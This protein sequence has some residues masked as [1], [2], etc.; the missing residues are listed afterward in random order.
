MTERE[1]FAMLLVVSREE[2]GLSQLDVSKKMGVSRRTVQNWE[3]GYSAPD[4]PQ[5]MQWFHACDANPMRYLLWYEY[6]ELFDGLK[7]DADIETMRRVVISYFMHATLPEIAGLLYIY[8]GRHGSDPIAAMQEAIANLHTPL[9]NRVS[10]CQLIVSNY[11]IAQ[12]TGKDPQP[13]IL[14]PNIELLEKALT[15]GHKAAML[16]HKAYSKG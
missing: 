14:Q 1:R 16:G 4:G 3:L 7:L 15:E 9:E 12:A 5:L 11:K 6:P 13:G 2:S 8:G 10:V